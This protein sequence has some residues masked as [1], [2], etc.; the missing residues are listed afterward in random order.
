MRALIGVFAR[1]LRPNRILLAIQGKNGEQSGFAAARVLSCRLS[2][3]TRSADS[4]GYLMESMRCG[5]WDNRYEREAR[6]FG[7][8]DWWSGTVDIWEKPARKRRRG[9]LT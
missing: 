1:R 6:E 2:V 7:G 9:E 8:R 5:Y 3:G 4:L